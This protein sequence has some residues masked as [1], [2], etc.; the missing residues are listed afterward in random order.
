MKPRDL[1][2]PTQTTSISFELELRHAPEKVWRAL[3]DPHLLAEWLL[4]VSGLAL[5]VG[6]AFELSAPPQPGWD[7]RVQCRFMEIEPLRK[8]RYTWQVGDLDTEVTFTLEPRG[9]GCRL[10]LVQTGF[11]P[12]EKRNFHGARYGWNLMC[13]R[14]IAL[15]DRPLGGRTNHGENP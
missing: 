2:D 5:Q 9:A 10:S 15:L 7:G 4:P 11:N 8:L 13:E 6:A 3:T 12:G 1:T 14:L